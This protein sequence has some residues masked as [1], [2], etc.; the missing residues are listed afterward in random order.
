MTQ[1]YRVKVLGGMDYQR[2]FG[3]QD[4]FQLTRTD[5][6]DMVCFTGGTD[7]NPNIYHAKRH[8]YTA[9]SDDGRDQFEVDLFRRCRDQGK[10]MVGICRGA[11]LLC[12]LNGGRLFQH[13]SNHTQSHEAFVQFPGQDVETMVVT[14][15]H[16]QMMD[17]AGHRN[18]QVLGWTNSRSDT[19]EN[20]EGVIPRGLWPKRD[21]EV[22]YFPETKCLAHQPHPE[23]MT[24]DAPYR[25]FFFDTVVALL[26]DNLNE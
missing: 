9:R 10:P 11:Q 6:Y 18:V 17:L 15:S 13:V 8:P 5:D 25:K 4:G 16:H 2:I 3:E 19:Y 14:S 26:E 24:E 1:N 22:A 21:I 7:I 20:G 12:A 23:W